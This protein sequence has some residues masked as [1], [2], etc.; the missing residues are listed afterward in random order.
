MTFREGPPVN[1]VP[2]FLW[3]PL[4]FIYFLAGRIFI[5]WQ[6]SVHN[7]H[8]SKIM[9]SK[10][11]H[12]NVLQSR[13]HMACDCYATHGFEGDGFDDGSMWLL[14]CKQLQCASENLH[15]TQSFWGREYFW[16][17]KCGNDLS[18]V[19]LEDVCFDKQSVCLFGHKYSSS[20]RFIFPSQQR[21]VRIQRY[22]W[23]LMSEVRQKHCARA[24]SLPWPHIRVWDY[25]AN[26]NFEKDPSTEVW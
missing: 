5:H 3:S 6:E 12:N 8:F 11:Q 21:R 24:S 15:N 10:L 9:M 19:S 17:H 16:L 13:D 7:K 20:R 26:H 25:D 22:S 1:V 14:G 2:V 23:V 18:H 4:P